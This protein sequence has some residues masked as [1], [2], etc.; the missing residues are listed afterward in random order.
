MNLPNLTTVETN[1]NPK[2]E[3]NVKVIF[4][5]MD[6]ENRW[7]VTESERGYAKKCKYPR[8]LSDFS[9][10]VHFLFLRKKLFSLK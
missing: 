9:T 3:K 7:K 1:Y 10:Q 5:R 4:K 8:D 2:A 6:S